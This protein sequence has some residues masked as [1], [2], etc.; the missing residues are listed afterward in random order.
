MATLTATLTNMKPETVSIMRVPHQAF[1]ELECESPF[2]GTRVCIAKGYVPTGAT[3]VRPPLNEDTYDGHS[4]LVSTFVPTHIDGYFPLTK[5]YG[6]MQYKSGLRTIYK[7]YDPISVT[8]HSSFDTREA[9]GI[10]VVDIPV[11]NEKQ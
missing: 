8:A 6:E 2:F 10:H 1:K 3:V 4:R 7:L 11:M 9:S 5:C